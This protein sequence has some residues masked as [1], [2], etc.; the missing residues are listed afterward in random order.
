MNPETPPPPGAPPPPGYGGPPPG[1]GGGPPGYGGY[2]RQA[3]NG[4]GIAALVLGIIGLL[5]SFFLVGGLFGLL[6]VIFGVMGR[7]RAKRGEATNGGMAL[8]GLIL[9]ALALAIALFVGVIIA[10]FADDISSYA[11]CVEQAQTQAE[12]DKCARDFQTNLEQ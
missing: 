5:S 9:G 8:A 10:M 11:D 7:G 1:Y 12:I 2:G 4:M 6:A 3:K